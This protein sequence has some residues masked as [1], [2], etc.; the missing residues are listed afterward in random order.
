MV[1]HSQASIVFFGTSKFA[2][3]AL[4]GLFESK[5]EIA[6]VI[7]QPAKPAGRK[8]APLPSPVELWA[9]EH[10]LKIEYCLP[11]GDPPKGKKLKISQ[12]DIFI[13]ASYGKIIP[14]EILDI[15]KYGCLNIHPSLLPKYRGASPIQAA[16]LNGDA[17]TGVT[18]IKMDEKMDHGPVLGNVKFQMSN[19]KINYK[20]LHDKLAETGANLLIK[21]LPKYIA[22]E[23]KQ[24]A[25][26]EAQATFTKIITKDDGK[27][28]WQDPAEKIERMIRA[29]EEWPIA[30]TTLDGKRLKTF[31]AAI[32]A[33]P[34]P[35]PGVRLGFARA[36][37]VGR[38]TARPGEVEIS[39][40]KEIIV[41]TGS[42]QLAITELQLEG[43]KKMNARNFINGYKNLER[44]ILI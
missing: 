44:K 17:E 12:T 16:I 5:Y 34:L 30:W 38:V 42:G 28:N 23:I 10:N 25:Q 27:I 15:P 11:A 35:S 26:D 43:G 2:I 19:V 40:S 24:E 21:T 29:Y 8:Q 22:G 32:S 1:K 39:N 33:S 36:R 4:R 3:P 41:Q 31:N 6:T 18:I 13:V 7:T 20:E 14:K 9:K 37:R